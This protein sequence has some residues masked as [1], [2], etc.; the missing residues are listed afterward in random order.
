MVQSSPFL[1]SLMT[2]T[3]FGLRG[4]AFMKNTEGLNNCFTL[5]KSRFP[6]CSAKKL[7]SSPAM[8]CKLYS[9][10]KAYIPF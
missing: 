2:K 9:K 1:C 6:L 3:N 8:A 4:F 7:L 5:E 10:G